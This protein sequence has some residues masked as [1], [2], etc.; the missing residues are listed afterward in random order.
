MPES[1]DPHRAHPLSER[2]GIFSKKKR[3]LPGSSAI[4]I[5]RRAALCALRA[6]FSF[7]S[8]VVKLLISIAIPQR[9]QL[10]PC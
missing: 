5:T 3:E 7:V 4:V 6:S 10:F 8:F 9:C 2:E 1:K